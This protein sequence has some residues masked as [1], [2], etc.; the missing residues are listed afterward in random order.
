MRKILLVTDRFY[1]FE[2][3]LLPIARKLYERYGVSSVLLMFKNP[4]D[5][6]N[7]FK[8]LKDIPFI[9][10]E[11]K[12]SGSSLHPTHSKQDNCDNSPRIRPIWLKALSV[13]PKRMRSVGRS[14]RIARELLDTVQLSAIIFQK[15]NKE[16]V[17]FLVKLAR[18]RGIKTVA[19]Q[20][21]PDA[22]Y[23][24]HGKQTKR[25]NGKE[26]LQT[27]LRY[28]LHFIDCIAYAVLL[29]P[30]NFFDLRHHWTKGN[31]DLFC[32]EN[33]WFRQGY[34]KNGCSPDKI[35]VTG[36]PEADSFLAE[37]KN[38]TPEAKAKKRKSLKTLDGEP[39]LL[40]VMTNGKHFN[41]T[42]RI[43]R[44]ERIEELLAFININHPTL[45]IWLS[46]HPQEDQCDYK[47]FQQSFKRIQVV[48]DASFSLFLSSDIV[49]T[50]GSTS[51]F[52]AQWINKPS[53]IYNMLTPDAEGWHAARASYNYK[54]T[55]L[56]NPTSVSCWIDKDLNNNFD[57][58]GLDWSYCQDGRACERIA[59][60]TL[61]GQDGCA[62]SETKDGCGI[63]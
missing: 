37:H 34:I 59:D 47:I 28:G 58:C 19:I 24:Y 40:L 1:H 52:L 26:I 43:I 48:G 55:L 17:P 3:N 46:V 60:L 20:T 21:N 30:I 15:G 50:E 22:I 13:I 16:E 33:E 2:T 41:Q 49:I 14:R 56:D 7:K 18:T 39:V 6:I 45:K 29:T 63:A 38:F 31:V 62:H 42:E 57:K 23:R 27:L 9:S 61:L 12:D 44:R 11:D 36:S 32:I 54:T 35:V 5:F 53:A 25:W 10:L 51:I 4:P 8:T